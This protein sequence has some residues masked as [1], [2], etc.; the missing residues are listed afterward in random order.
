MQKTGPGSNFPPKV[1]IAE[2]LF[3][4]HR[5]G[6][7]IKRELASGEERPLALL[8]NGECDWLCATTVAALAVLVL[9]WCR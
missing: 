8:D 7:G 2:T 9:A 1:V 6:E 4:Q 3:A 5:A